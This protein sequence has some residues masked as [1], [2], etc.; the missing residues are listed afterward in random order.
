MRAWRVAD[1]RWEV[2][3]GVLVGGGQSFILLRH[4]IE[5]PVRIEYDT[6]AQSPHDLSAL[7]SPDPDNYFAGYLIAFAQRSTGSRIEYPGAGVVYTDTPLAQG[8]PNQWHHVIAQVLADGKA[9]LVVDG[10]LL[11]EFG[12]AP[13]PTVAGYAGLWTWHGGE[14]DNV[15]IYSGE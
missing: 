5:A 3:Q 14:F 10:Q 15:R 2:S 1:G 12:E 7:W 9:Q 11:L 8:V 13:K 4:G 6:R